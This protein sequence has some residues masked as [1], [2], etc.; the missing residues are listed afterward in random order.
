MTTWCWAHNSDVY[1]PA[2]YVWKAQIS[3]NEV[4]LCEDCCAKWRV[5]ARAEP[6]LEPVW[7]RTLCP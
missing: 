2:R 1:Q 5:N 6:D 4:P 3:G 7:I